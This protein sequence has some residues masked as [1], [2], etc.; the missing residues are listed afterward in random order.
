MVGDSST[1]VAT[2]SAANVPVVAVDF[3]YTEI[4][5]AELAADR[6]ISRFAD[7]PAVVFELLAGRSDALVRN[8]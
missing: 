1:D 2:A 7:L 6:V 8:G 4:P 3:G 5:V